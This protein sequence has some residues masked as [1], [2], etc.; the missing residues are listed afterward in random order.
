[1]NPST[2]LTSL[3]K[4]NSLKKIARRITPRDKIEAAVR[5]FEQMGL[6][7]DD[8]ETMARNVGLEA[9]DIYLASS[10]STV[11]VG[12]E[13]SGSAAKTTVELASNLSERL[14]KVED[15]LA[16]LVAVESRMATPSDQ[17]GD[18]NLVTHL[19]RI[20]DHFDP[21][22][23]NI[24]GTPYV[25]QKL[26]CTTVWVTEMIRLGQIPT[27][28]VVPGTGNGKPWK[29]HRARIDEWMKKR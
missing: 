27:S 23:P 2:E 18:E 3:Q 10:E 12:A 13:Q 17:G 8:V 22:P 9:D 1:M 15:A 25:A 5:R 7:R 20:A 16:R 14:R 21:P 24:V 11:I 26:N 28:C 19:R 4:L 6:L 29:F